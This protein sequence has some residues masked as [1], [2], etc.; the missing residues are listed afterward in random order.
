MP[1]FA[2]VDDPAPDARDRPGRRLRPVDVGPPTFDVGLSHRP[3]SV[4]RKPNP[5]AAIFVLSFEFSV[6][7]SLPPSAEIASSSLIVPGVLS[8]VSDV[9]RL[10]NSEHDGQL[11]PTPL[12][13]DRAG[14]QARC[15]ELR[16]ASH[17]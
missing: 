16:Q 13:H 10:R 8:P 14:P 5:Y 1:H 12:L 15:E 6:L 9:K 2:E 17:N 7:G 4:G 11:R 3:L